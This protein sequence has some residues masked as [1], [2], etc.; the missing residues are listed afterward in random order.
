MTAPGPSPRDAARAEIRE[1]LSTRRARITPEQAG[2]PSFGGDRRRVVLGVGLASAG[3]ARRLRRSVGL[4][5][6]DGL[7][8]RG[9]ED[10]SPAAEGGLA[11]GDLLVAA[12]GRPLLEVDD[13]YDL[14]DATG[15]GGTIELTVLR[16]AEERT[17]AVTFPAGE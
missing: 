10:G 2:L 8:V 12:G 7:L 1:F 9:V 14:L 6:H 17:V 13:L 16:G 4:P 11:E 3:V 15:P 5:E